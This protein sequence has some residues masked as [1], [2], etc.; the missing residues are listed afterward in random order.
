[1]LFWPVMIIGIAVLAL[2]LSQPAPDDVLV[3]GQINMRTVYL[4]LLTT[5]LVIASAVRLLLHGGY[6]TLLHTAGWL[7]AI[8]GLATAFSYRDQASQII[9]T[10]RAELSE[11]FASSDGSRPS[12]LER[13]W[14]GHYLAEAEVNGVPVTLMVDTGAT[15]VLIP[16]EQAAAIGLKV[17]TLDFSMPVTTANGSTMVA[18]FQ[19]SSIRIQHVAVFDIP[20]AVAQPGRLK[21][22]LLGMSFLEQLG[23]ASVQG[24]RM[25]LR[26]TRPEVGVGESSATTE[27]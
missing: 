5:T 20:G 18:P 27:N 6:K 8:A 2:L 12:V 3:G 26:Q 19:I 4:V 7:G 11:Q 22:G 10:V 16:Y 23:E 9:N 15:M 25:I 14:D 21:T 24:N 1:M 17:D 13:D